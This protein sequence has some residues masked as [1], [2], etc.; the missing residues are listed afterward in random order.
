MTK[1]TP[2]PSKLILTHGKNNALIEHDPLLSLYLKEIQKYPLLSREEEHELLCEYHATKS[3]KILERLVTSNLRFVVKIAFE[4]FNYKIRILDLIQEGNLGLVKAIQDFNPAKDNRLST[5]AV[6]WIRSYI[7]EAILKNYSLVKIGTTQ[8]QKKLFYNLRKEQRKLEQIGI[9]PQEQVP[10]IAKA[11]DVHEDEVREMSERLKG[12]T[13]SLSE[14]KGE[15]HTELKM[16]D[17]QDEA[18]H[19]LE[20][21][22]QHEESEIFTHILKEFQNG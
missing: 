17:I 13:L 2:N 22:S 21:L 15:T 18:P 11:L 14:K 5:Y 19:F 9:R 6:W 1:V 10:L 4:Y 7:Q 20:T 8:A 3:K 12:D 16:S